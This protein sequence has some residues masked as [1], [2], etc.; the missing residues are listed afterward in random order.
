M[1]LFLVRLYTPWGHV[2]CL[3]CSWLYPPMLGFVITGH[4][5][6]CSVNQPLDAKDCYSCSEVSLSLWCADLI[7][8]LV[9]EKGIFICWAPWQSWDLDIM[10]TLEF[11]G[12]YMPLDQTM[13]LFFLSPLSSLFSMEPFAKVDTQILCAVFFKASSLLLSRFYACDFHWTFKL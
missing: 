13:Y 5:V 6:V 9:L 11:P 2:Q 12:A 1:W 4:I 8:A 7:K 3:S 10:R